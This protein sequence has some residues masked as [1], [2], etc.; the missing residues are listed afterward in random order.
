[1]TNF[2]MFTDSGNIIIAGV[3]RAAKEQKWSWD[4]VEKKLDELSK[5]KMLE[6][7]TD[8]MVREAIWLYLYGPVKQARTWNGQPM[9]DA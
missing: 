9:G 3:S 5:Q 8:T 7:C 4:R 6:E 1:M 2:E